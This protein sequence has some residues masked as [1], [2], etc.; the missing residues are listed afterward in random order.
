MMILLAVRILLSFNDELLAATI[1]LS[2]NSDFSC[3]YDI[4]LF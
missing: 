2:F 1:L 4:A 3:C